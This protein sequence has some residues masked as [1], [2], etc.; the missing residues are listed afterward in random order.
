MRLTQWLEELWQDAIFAVRQLKSA[1]GFA[2]TAA[3]TLALGIGGNS[4][5]FALVDAAL[6]RPLP[7]HEPDRLVM[8]WERHAT[9]ARGGVAPL[10]LLDWNERNRTFES[11]AGFIPGVGGMV[12]N[13]ADGTA[14]TVPRQW[15]TAGIFDVLGIK[16]I[17]GRTMVSSDDTQRASVV[18]LSEAFWRTRFNADPAVVGHEIRLDGE[19]YS[20]IGV[21]PR[22][23]Q[24]IGRTSIWAM[25]PI[26]GAPPAA[27][28]AHFLRVIGRT[29]PGVTLEAAGADLAQIAEA[30]ERDF[31]T[32]NKGRGVSLE[33]LDAAVVGSE[34]RFTSMLFLGVVGF[35]LLICCANVANLLMTRA[36]VRARELAIRSALGAG[37]ARVTRQLLTESLVLAMLGGVLGVG[38]GAAILAVAPAMIPEGLL[39]G[40]VTLAFDMRVVAFCIAAALL[41]GL[42][43]GMAPA[44][45]ATELSSSHVITSSRGATGGG[46]RLRNVLVAGEVATAVALLFGAGLLLRTLSS[47]DNVDRGYGADQ[48]LTMMVDPLGSSYPTPESLEQFFRAIDDEVMAVP[49]VR[50]VAWASTLPLG[51]SD[52]GPTEFEI[53]GDPPPE[54]SKRPS[55]DFQIVSPSYFETLDLP[56]VAGRAFDDRDARDG[57]P[58]CI[59]NEAFV[60]RHLQGRSAIGMRIAFP[61]AS[62]QAKP[63]VR[64]IVG[65]AR[66]VKG[67]PDEAED[68]FQ[69]YVPLAQS[70]RDDIYLLVRPASGS[71]EGLA[72]SVRAAIGRVDREQLVSVRSVMTLEDVASGATARHRF[73]AVLVMAFAGLA[74]LLAMVGVFGILAYAVQ[75][76]VRDIGVR[77]ALGATTRDV[78]GLVLG[79]VARVIAAGAVIGLVLSAVLGRL[80]AT[81][82][83]G[84]EPLDPLTFVSVTVLLALAAGIAAV[85]PAWRAS[86][87]DPAVALRTD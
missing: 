29:R 21:V 8:V 38:V 84:V 31:P 67:R 28:G 52:A 32:T 54:A 19:L 85:G 15:V 44:W 23:A 68:F 2:A 13:G 64:E 10:N 60:R 81:L 24:L 20:I 25:S 56:V 71:A 55:A 47:L 80:I 61:S 3:I 27:R 45:Q 1:P 26:Q 46:G 74:L 49:G 51:E 59:V 4:A 82:L 78:I 57:V 36:T 18:V 6:L 73:R 77:R 39:P 37:R 5:I 12:M 35:V 43:F 40:A 79:G 11:M 70:L 42:L 63:V 66:Q 16:P 14:E 33:R 69:I 50:N 22:E 86:R 62:A 76:R 72:R 83:F 48:V 7:F 75:Q 9:S 53:V 17:V 58:V 87:I 34:L 30:L 41:V 65:V